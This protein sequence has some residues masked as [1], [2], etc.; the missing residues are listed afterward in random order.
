MKM[1]VRLIHRTPNM[2]VYEVEIDGRAKTE[3][4]ISDFDTIIHRMNERDMAYSRAVT[5]A[6]ECG[7]TEEE[8]DI[9]FDDEIDDKRS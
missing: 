1:Y 4:A 6:I 7:F 3:I 5:F 9:I 2:G 8:L